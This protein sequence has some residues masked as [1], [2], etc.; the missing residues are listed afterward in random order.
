MRK[1]N[2]SSVLL[3]L[4]IGL[5]DHLRYHGI[6]REYCKKYKR[7]AIFSVPRFYSSVSFMYR[8]IKNLA[9]IK[10]DYIGREEY[11]FAKKFIFLNKF[12]F[13]K[14]KYDLVK[15]LENKYLDRYSGVTFEE[16]LYR[17]AGVDFEKKWDSFFVERD[18]EKEKN[19]FKRFAP[20]GDFVFFHEDISRN[21][22]I[23]KEKINKKCEIFTP[24]E[25]LTNNIFDYCAIIEKAKEIHVIDSSF[26]FLIDCLQYENNE[27]KLFV[28]RYTRGNAEYSLPVLKKKWSII[29]SF[30]PSVKFCIVTPVYNGGKH[31]TETIESV[32]SQEGDFFIDYIIADGGSTDESIK[33]IKKYDNLLKEGLYPIKCNGIK[34]RWWSRRS[35]GQ[36]SVINEGFKSCNGEI[37][38]WINSGDFYEPDAFKITLKKF[39]ED[40]SIDLV[41][42]NSFNYYNNGKKEL[43]RSRKTDFD[44]LL[45]ND[46]V[47]FQSSTFFTK[48]ALLKA[49]F[50]DENLHYAMDIDLWIKIAENSTIL[51]MPIALSNFRA[52]ENSKMTLF[53][54]N[55]SRE[56]RIILWKYKGGIISP[57]F[58]Q[59][60]KSRNV[61]LKY[62]NKKIPRFYSYCK[63][64]FYNLISISHY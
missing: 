62:I 4:P 16:Q 29:T 24:N 51:Y 38:A 31:I 59:L 58:I 11:V 27:Q 5:G 36:S 64:K 15:T 53:Y 32:L 56:R 22:L 33:I 54:K 49:A 46:N 45:K 25:N 60:I 6:V 26:M 42:G 44:D 10:G 48:R 41:Y 23:N 39:Q 37:F 2:M 17:L 28:H 3:Y 47:I 52:R 21:H 55:F 9:I 63:R 50:L 13:G 57:K 30:E 1:E 18:Y 61:F 34:L 20:K 7:V 8:D 14:Y 43:A 19:I 35:N 12:K 40:P